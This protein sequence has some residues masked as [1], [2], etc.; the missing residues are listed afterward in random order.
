MSSCVFILDEQL[1]PLILRNLKSIAHPEWYALY[2][3]RVHPQS[4]GP[5]IYSKG[6][7][8][9]YILRDGLYFV[10]V[11]NG[12]L[13]FNL[14][15][16]LAY[17][18]DFHALLVKYLKVNKVDR[19][20]II[21]NF[22]LIYELFDESLDYGIPQLTDYNIIRDSIKIEANVP[23]VPSNSQADSDEESGPEILQSKENKDK[24]DIH[25]FRDDEQ[26]INSFVLR[27][28]TQAIS[29]RPKGIYYTKN[30]LF[31]DI[32]ERQSYLMDFKNSQVR[33]TFVYG[34][35][36]CRSYLSGM[37]IVRVCINKMLKDKDLFLGS[38]KFHQCVSLE[39]LS[40][41]DYIE[42][43][44]PDGDFQLCEYKLKRH[45]NDSPIIKLIDYK[46][47]ERQK[48]HRLHL[49][50]TIQPHF[51]AQN[52]ATALKIHIPIRDLFQNYK[53]DLTK[54]PRFKCDHGSVFFNLSDELLL[55]DAQGIKGG[56]G[57][58]SYSMHVEFALFDE[59]EHA[60]KLEQIKNSMDPPPLREG[61]HLEELYAQVKS[62]KEGKGQFQSNA[63]TTE[64]EVPYY[65][66]SGLRVEYLKIS[67]ENLK[68]QSF[69]WVRYKT[70]ND[71]EYAYQV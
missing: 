51:K 8:Y 71:T 49:S 60:R 21:D 34:K 70:I 45:I 22:N 6:I 47:N 66:S 11:S 44:P 29:W 32:I 58:T 18:N 26:Y 39:S 30:E 14:M 33:Q 40:S 46:I 24:A 36:N 9:I 15:G 57:E 35:I 1:N 25:G 53:I 28:T 31:V 64:F 16:I 10:S 61:A 42:F 19:T 4:R 27:T 13:R 23:K 43:I 41:Q 20:G 65:T 12:G 55:W 69:S 56:H 59:E 37:P 54:A 68:Y 38:S 17:L 2:F 50:V 62:N 52:S 3:K 48:K 7:L 5:V 67:E 63:I